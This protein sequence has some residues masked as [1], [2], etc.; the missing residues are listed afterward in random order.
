[1]TLKGTFSGNYTP[2]L[3]I[4]SVVEKFMNKEL[5]LEKFITHTLPILLNR[6]GFLN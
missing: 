3:D 6:Q 5:E 1:M 4:P 2:R